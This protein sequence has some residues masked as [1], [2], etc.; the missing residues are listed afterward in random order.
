[1]LETQLGNV[2]TELR[3]CHMHSGP[4]SCGGNTSL[5]IFVHQMSRGE[6]QYS[7]ASEGGGQGVAIDH[8]AEPRYVNDHG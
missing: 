4:L 2:I 1:M 3:Q 5:S 6:S 7:S 8:D